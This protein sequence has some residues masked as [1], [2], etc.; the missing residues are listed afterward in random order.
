[1]Q[2]ILFPYAV[3]TLSFEESSIAQKKWALYASGIC[4]AKVLDAIRLSKRLRIDKISIKNRSGVIGLTLLPGRKDRN[5]D[6]PQDIKTLKE[7]GVNRV[8]SLLTENEYSE[9]GVIEIKEVYKTEG[10]D[11]IFFPILDQR[12]PDR[13]SL[14]ELLEK[15]D[16]D[17][18]SGKNVL[19]H[20]VGGLG[21][22]GTIVAAYLILCSGYTVD[23]AIRT[24]REVRSERAIESIEQE[25]FLRNLTTS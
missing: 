10:L 6:L 23:E 5:R 18:L 21:R 20:C 12:I 13:K 22:S 16:K 24:V 7:E 2:F 9:Y 17:L 8:I 15:I 1:M 4:A 11:P 3:H 19:I 25:E 14:N